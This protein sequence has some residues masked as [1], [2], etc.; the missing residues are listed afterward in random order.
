[1]KL[2]IVEIVL[3]IIS[4]TMYILFKNN[5]FGVENHNLILIILLII[6]FPLFPIYLILFSWNGFD[7]PMLDYIFDFKEED[8]ITFY[9]INLL[10]LF[11]FVLIYYDNK[12]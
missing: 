5:Y 12:I 3:L 10:L 2:I 11:T 9:V 1:M 4:L 6:A 7:Y 8:V